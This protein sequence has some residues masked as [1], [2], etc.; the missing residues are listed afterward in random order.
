VSIGTQVS[1]KL[2]RAETGYFWFCPACGDLHP[3]PDRWTFD[4]NL[5]AP[6]FTPSFKH[7][8]TWGEE[9]EARCC[10]YIVTAGKV[11][12]CGD[13]THSMANQTIDMPH[14][15]EEFCDIAKRSV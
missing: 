1:S 8:W 11:T 10:H 4:G 12:Y 7:T 9:R 14:L 13:C 6:T 2:R 15:P 3:L 5:E